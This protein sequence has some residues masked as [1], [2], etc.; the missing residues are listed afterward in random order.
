[1]DIR[2]RARFFEVL[3]D[4]VPSPIFFKDKEGVY[5]SCNRAFEEYTCLSKDKI[6]GKT[7][8]DL[9]CEKIAAA[10]HEIDLS[11]I[12]NRQVQYYEVSQRNPDGSRR[13]TIFHKACYLDETGSVIGLVGVLIDVTERRTIEEERQ[14]LVE[15]LQAALAEV[16]TLRGLLPIC[17][18]CK[19][20]RDDT[21]Y[22]HQLEIY[23]E[24]HS[25]VRFSHGICDTCAKSYYSGRPKKHRDT[26][27]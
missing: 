24:G 27:K 17:S 6:L 22:W 5:R 20:I 14:R 26:G 4:A 9:G 15:S 23:I 3:F 18:H 10:H 12:R 13:D 1:M 25:D 19:K 8:Y 11:L 21:G 2:D 7:D 16:K